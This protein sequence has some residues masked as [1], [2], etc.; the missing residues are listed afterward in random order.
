M[1]ESLSSL[2]ESLIAQ[3]GFILIPVFKVTILLVVM[4][5]YVLG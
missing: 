5:L 1:E 3:R 4:Y 2:H